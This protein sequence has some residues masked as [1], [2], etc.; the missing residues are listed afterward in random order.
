MNNTPFTVPPRCRLLDNFIQFAQEQRPKVSG[1]GSI[2]DIER[3]VGY[4]F[5]RFLSELSL[6]A[7]DGQQLQPQTAQLTLKLQLQFTGPDIFTTSMTSAAI[8]YRYRVNVYLCFAAFDDSVDLSQFNKLVFECLISK[9]DLSRLRRLIY[10]RQNVIL[11][12]V[13]IG[14]KVKRRKTHQLPQIK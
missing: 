1:P 8:S 13:S 5:F 12:Y 7:F 2:K 4:Q 6:T 10:L 14:V 3:A 11:R 9:V